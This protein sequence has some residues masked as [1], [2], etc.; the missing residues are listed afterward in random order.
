MTWNWV[1]RGRR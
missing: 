1:I